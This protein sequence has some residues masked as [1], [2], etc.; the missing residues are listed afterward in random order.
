MKHSGRKHQLTSSPSI[1]VTIAIFAIVPFVTNC[2]GEDPPDWEQAISASDTA[3]PT[4]TPPTTDQLVVYLD[5][6]GSMAGY[7][8]KDGQNVFGRTLRAVR[9][10][11]TSFKQPVRVSV[12]Y[13]ASTVNSP[14]PDGALALQKASIDPSV[15]RGGETDLAGAISSFNPANEQQSM[16][17][18]GTQSADA[19][20][21]PI[22]TPQVTAPPPPR[23]HILITDGV[24]STRGQNTKLACLKGSDATCVREKIINLIKNGWGGYVIG[25]RS[26]FHG[27]VYSETG[28]GSFVYDTPE[29]NWKRYRPFYL[30]VFSPD[31]VALDEFV[32]VL[33]ERLRPIAQD[34][35]MRVL[36]LTS[37]YANEDVK[38]ELTIPNESEGAVELSD[39]QEANQVRFTL[40]VH[41]DKDEATPA[42]FT[43]AVHVPWSKQVQ[44]SAPPQELAKLIRWEV[45]PISTP[46]DAAE[47]PGA[48]RYPSLKLVSSSGTQ[49]L[50]QQGRVPVQLV[51]GW[52]RSTAKPSWRVFRLQGR[53]NV[54]MENDPLPWIRQWSTDLDRSAE[55]ADRTLDLQTVLISLWRNP[56][57]QQQSLIK[58]YLRV[59]PQ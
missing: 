46:E 55:F 45:E 41:H 3:S 22:E 33:R 19:K 11:A 5:T 38:A 10:V 37:R 48:R 4:P 54:S 35:S 36:A 7:A 34:E 42:P 47:A 29:G 49:A 17:R 52:P 39:E 18:Q 24:Q 59:G 2:G 53:L 56:A 43:V 1:W 15:Y 12:R 57:L 9:D 25:L 13:V 16:Q 21:L 32:D 8:T 20:S 44:D 23:F 27:K 31:P 14:D 51:V 28:G 50:D 26:Q 6:S 30:Y 40:E 58:V